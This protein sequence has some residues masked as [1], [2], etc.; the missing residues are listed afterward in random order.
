[1][2]LALSMF[3]LATIWGIS[4]ETGMELPS[5]VRWSLYESLAV[6]VLEGQSL[7]DHSGRRGVVLRWVRAFMGA[8]SEI[9]PRTGRAVVTD[10]S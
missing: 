3:A 5:A 10:L 9:V 8:R 6:L 1:V 7:V 4:L 2:Y